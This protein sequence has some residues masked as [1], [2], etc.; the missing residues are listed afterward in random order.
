VLNDE[1]QRRR[2]VLKSLLEAGG[3]SLPG[4]QSRFA[5]MPLSDLPMLQELLAYGLARVEN[6]VMTLT[7]SGL[8]RSDTIGP[9]LY[10]LQARQLMEEYTLR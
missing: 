4:Y 1:E 6:E 10:S 2:Y 8:E 7:P 5:S 3:L 9:W